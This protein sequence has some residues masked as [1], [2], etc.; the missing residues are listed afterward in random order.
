MRKEDQG[1]DDDERAN[2]MILCETKQKRDRERERE[3]ERDRQ[4][5]RQKELRHK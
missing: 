4:T 5:S 1:K 3:R 2:D